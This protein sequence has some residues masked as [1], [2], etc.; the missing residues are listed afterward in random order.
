M[1]AV[2]KGA[3]HSRAGKPGHLDEVGFEPFLDVSGVFRGL[4]PATGFRQE[5]NSCCTVIMTS[6]V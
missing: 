2:L 5:H 6:L 3:G 4:W 1:Q